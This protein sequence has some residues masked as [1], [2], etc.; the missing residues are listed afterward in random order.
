MHDDIRLAKR[1]AGGDGRAFAELVDVYGPRIHRLVRRY[2]S[3]EADAE[4]LT[5]EIFVALYRSMGQFRGGSTL[6][7]WVYRVALNHCLKPRRAPQTVDYDDDALHGQEEDPAGNPAL[8]AARQELGDQIERA[9]G[10]LSPEQRDVVV[11]HELHDFTYSECA[12]LLQIPIG[13]VKSR[14]SVAFRRLRGHLDNYVRGVD[15]RGVDT[16]IGEA[17]P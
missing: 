6:A 13:T 3:S 10:H 9:L 17:R 2:A 15:T 12:S 7:T 8:H 1:I 11:L 16:P 14:L 4:D 5:Q